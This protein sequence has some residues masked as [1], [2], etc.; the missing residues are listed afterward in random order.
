MTSTKNKESSIKTPAKKVLSDTNSWY[1]I[2]FSV[3]I[4]ATVATRF[5]KVL[6]PDHVW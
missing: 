1:F 3:V 2:V 6:E 5:Y 4:V